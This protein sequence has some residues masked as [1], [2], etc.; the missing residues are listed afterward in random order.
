MTLAT[1]RLLWRLRHLASG[2]LPNGID[3]C[4]D[5]LR[6]L[7]IAIVADRLENV[8]RT[9]PLVVLANHPTGILDGAALLSALSSVRG[10]TRIMARA[11]ADD[12]PQVAPLLLAVPYGHS[13]DR[14]ARLRELTR[15]ARAHLAS[16][17]SV[18]L[19]PA[20]RIATGAEPEWSAFGVRLAQEVGA[21]VLPVRILDQPSRL[22]RFAARVHPISRQGVLL[23]EV[24][25]RAD[26]PFHIRIGPPMTPFNLTTESVRAAVLNL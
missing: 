15:T 21:A 1:P 4:N 3:L 20:G 7:G 18:A 9:G 5:A 26:K 13:V 10:D 14:R 12:M 16:G 6:A 8:P 17:G 23:H 24:L 25:R 11:L 2:P 19:F 22:Y